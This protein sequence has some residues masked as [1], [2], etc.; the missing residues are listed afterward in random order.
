MP[1]TKS[2]AA[3]AVIAMLA[4][5]SAAADVLHV[6][7]QGLDSPTCGRDPGHPCRSITRAIANANP[8]DTV[9]VGPG[10]YGDLNR[11]KDFSDPGEEAGEP[12]SDSG[13]VVCIHK[14]LRILSTH[15]AAATRIEAVDTH[16]FEL[17]SDNGYG[18][19]VLIDTSGVTFGTP[20]H[21]FQLAGPAFDQ[22][23][24]WLAGDV[25]IAGNIALRS[26]V[27]EPREL[28]FSPDVGFYAFPQGGT[29]TFTQNQ[30]IRNHVGFFVVGTGP[31]ELINNA[32]LQNAEVGFLTYGSGPKRL[33]G[34]YA[35]GNGDAPPSD[36]PVDGHP[37]FPSAAGFS[38]HADNSRLE[39]N[40]SVGNF[41]PGF[42]LA[43]SPPTSSTLIFL[44]HNAATGN[45]GPGILLGTGARVT[46]QSN[47]IYGNRG[48]GTGCGLI[49]QSGRTADAT[50]NFWGL[51]TGPGADPADKAGPG[52]GCDQ[53][54][55]SVTRVA[56]F[57]T[58]GFAVVP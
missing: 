1:V 5:G 15:G 29:V 36:D 57:A 55:G 34:N 43:Q 45:G 44:K 46:A 54:Q 11:D 28:D 12:S 7:N 20:G 21:G 56:P 27:R 22:L 39:D 13:C 52:S 2:L 47:N 3:S 42:L 8:G 18:S 51:A 9:L 32:A 50:N 33:I 19:L 49:N 53:G 14:R 25:A 31:A 6:G 48:A 24:V 58:T 10:F 23:T 40:L 17:G 26:E 41:G 4:S 38:I 16:K 30:A 35:S 37:I